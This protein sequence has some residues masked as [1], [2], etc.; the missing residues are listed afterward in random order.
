MDLPGAPFSDVVTAV[1][2]YGSFNN[3]YEE[4]SQGNGRIQNKRNL[5]DFTRDRKI[6]S[7]RLKA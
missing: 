7:K 4:M 1:C 5:Q 3:P 2:L 6:D